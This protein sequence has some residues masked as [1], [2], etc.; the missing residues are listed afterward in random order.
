VFF[1]NNLPEKNLLRIYDRWGA[2]IYMHRDYDNTWD[3]NK[4]ADGTYFYVLKTDINIIKGW[5]QIVR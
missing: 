1:I 5:I 2:L 4:Q 3:G